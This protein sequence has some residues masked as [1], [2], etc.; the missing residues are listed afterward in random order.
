M[1]TPSKSIL[2][3]VFVLIG[4]FLAGEIVVRWMFRTNC[5]PLYATHPTIEYLLKPSQHFVCDSKTFKTNRWS[6][7]SPDFPRNKS[8]E[9]I[10]VMVFGDSVVHGFRLD[11]NELATSLLAVDLEQ[12]LRRQAVVGNISAPSWG[13]PNC[14][15]YEQ[16]YGFFDADV[17][18]LVFSSHDL[19]DV[20]TFEPL[21]PIYQPQTRF[22]V[23]LPF[24]IQK[25]FGWL[26]HNGLQPLHDT[27]DKNL[28][29]L[30][31]IC[32]KALEDLYQDLQKQAISLL[33]V[34]HYQQD[35][36]SAEMTNVFMDW[37]RSKEVRIVS[38]REAL[39]GALNAGKNP[40]Q[41]MI[42]LNELGQNLLEAVILYGLCDM[43]FIHLPAQVPA[44][45]EGSPSESSTPQ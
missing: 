24:G 25:L 23:V 10:R 27:P 30:E 34:L 40:Y 17:V 32:L 42:H 37:A 7:R 5:Y 43:G 19:Y 1:R 11:Q 28:K 4:L 29:P 38:D 3:I 18:V 6:M 45:S 31:A 2:W 22:H 39:R 41:D 44:E 9:E 33:L 21:S 8:L 36:L 15:A 26:K 35:E 20:P 12:V 16:A 13:V 14:L